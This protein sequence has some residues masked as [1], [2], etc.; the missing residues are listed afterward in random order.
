V[1]TLPRLRT[2]AKT[3]PGL[4]LGRILEERS[5][6][7]RSGVCVIDVRTG[8]IVHWLYTAAAVGELF[9]VALLAGV[10][11]PMALAFDSELSR[12]FMTMGR[13]AITPPAPQSLEAAIPEEASTPWPDPRPPGSSR[14]T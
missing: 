9:D 10:S 8:E 12:R 14:P 6:A 11:R 2:A 13:E 3:F 5:Q 1:V 7:A 4:S